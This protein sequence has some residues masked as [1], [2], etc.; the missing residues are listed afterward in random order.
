MYE[1]FT[2]NRI[3]QL[4]M[5]KNVSARDMSLTLGQNNSYINQI[6]NKKALKLEENDYYQYQK[7]EKMKMSVNDVTPEKMEKGIYKKFS[8]FKDQVEVSP[9]TNK[10]ILPISIKETSSKT[11]YRKNPKSEKTNYR[12]YELQRHRR[13]LQ[14]RRYA[15]HDPHRRLFR[16]QHLR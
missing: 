4:R 12:G 10:M 15:G 6:E 3:A 13:I 16:R 2:Q 5:Q 8:F 14:Y 7:Y 1:E 11:I 9:K